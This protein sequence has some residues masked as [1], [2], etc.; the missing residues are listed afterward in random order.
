LPGMLLIFRVM[1]L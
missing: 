1:A